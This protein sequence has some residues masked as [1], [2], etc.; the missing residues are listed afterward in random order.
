MIKH[1]YDKGQG[2]GKKEDIGEVLYNRGLTA[3]MMSVEAVKRAQI[4]YGKK[5]LKGE[6]VRWGL[7][8]LAIDDASIKK[9]GF[10]GFMTPVSTSCGNHSGDPTAGIHTWDGKKWIIEKGTRLSADQQI[11]RPMIRASAEKYAAEKKVTR[12]DCAKEQ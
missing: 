2:T 8:N 6:E 5:P 9:L 7:E 3:A 1:V 11:I 12:R 10:D 4:K